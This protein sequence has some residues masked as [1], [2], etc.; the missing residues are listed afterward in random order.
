MNLTVENVSHKYTDGQKTLE[1]LKGIN[2]EFEPGKIYAIV[3][4]SGS[5]KTTLI[6]L[7]AGLDKVQS[8]DIKYGAKS[9]KE[10]GQTKFRLKYV[11]IVF[12]SY[13]LIK[14][15]TAKENVQIALDFT[16]HDGDAYKLL[17]DV[18]IGHDMANRLVQKLSGGEQQ[19]VAI[20]RAMAGKVPIIVADEPTGNLDE[21]TEGIIL[22][23]LKKLA[24]E[25]RIV[26]VVTHSKNVAEKTGAVVLHMEHGVLT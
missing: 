21:G 20:A 9:I 1:V 10:I 18:G 24:N 22:E 26:I 8:G 19:R 13:N 15:M 4:E 6:S 12:Q 16:G 2:A 14:Y 7:I 17:E 5:G 25:G 23:L 3:G 11:N